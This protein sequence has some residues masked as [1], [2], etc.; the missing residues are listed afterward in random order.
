MKI[1]LKN[2]GEGLRRL[3]LTCEMNWLMGTEAVDRA[4]L[5]TWSR[6]GACFASGAMDGVGVLAADDCE[7]KAEGARL[8]IPLVLEG[9]IQR[10]ILLGWGEDMLAAEALARRFRRSII[11][12]ADAKEFEKMLGKLR[13]ETPDSAINAMANGFLQA[14]SLF[15]RILGRTGLYQPGGAYGFRDQLQ[16]MLMLLHYDPERVRRHILYCAARQFGEGDVLHWWH[17]P[18][19][20]VRTRIS[21]DLLFLPYVTA[22]YVK[23]TGDRGILNEEITFLEEIAIPE[24]REDIYAEMRP[25]EERGSL[26]EH[27]MRAFRRAAKTGVHGLCLMGSGDWNDGMNRVGMKGRGESVW[28]SMFM[29]VCAREYAEIAPGKDADW[30]KEVDGRLCAAVEEQGWDGGWYLRAYTDE[31]QKLGGRECEECRIDAISQAWAVFAGLDAA[32]VRSAVNAAWERLGDE[33]LGVIRLLTP[34]FEG[35]SCDPGYIAAY[36]PGVRENGAQYTHGACWLALALAEM[37]DARA[38]RA[39]EM[40]LPVYHADSRE[41]AERYRVEPYVMAADVYTDGVHAGRGGWTWYTGSAAW[42]LAAILGVLGYRRR[43]K[44][45]KLNSLL[46]EWESASITVEY[47]KSEY[48]LICR[49][50]VDGV[51]LDGVLMEAD[52]IEM[53][54]DGKSHVCLFPARASA[55]KI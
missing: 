24:G 2:R 10:R 47:G 51:T 33:S 4:L 12:G 29:A 23:Q 7:A 40:L 35:K 27:C 28:L 14:Q 48:H 34:P 36:P 37:N 43:G 25:S 46:G 45:V 55:K 8:E 17:D 11:P 9:E 39:L 16:D 32:R 38:H 6:R 49:K 52:E 15:G 54:D 44:W 50:D 26:H 42:M 13:I 41:K 31:G 53:R 1:R 22:E 30:L 20:G 3:R 21:D 5:R 18:Y 19:T